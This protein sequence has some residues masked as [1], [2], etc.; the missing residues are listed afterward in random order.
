M[1]HSMVGCCFRLDPTARRSGGDKLG[2]TGDVRHRNC[3]GLKGFPA[4]TCKSGPACTTLAIFSAGG[5][6]DWPRD[7]F[8]GET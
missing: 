3:Q 2:G 8:L 7:G 5:S 4:E 6:R 1:I